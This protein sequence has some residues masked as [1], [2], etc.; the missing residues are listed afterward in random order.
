[1]QPIT[2]P[3]WTSPAPSTS[4]IREDADV[5]PDGDLVPMYAI[6]WIAS[7][8]RLVVAAISHETFGIEGTLALL[9][10]LLLPALFFESLRW[11]LR[12]RRREPHFTP[13]ADQPIARVLT[14]MPE[15]RTAARRPGRI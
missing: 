14:L 8:A 3:C 4:S 9:A 13:S 10:A 5:C 11:L 2:H 15:D 6:V 7:V 12:L 1:M